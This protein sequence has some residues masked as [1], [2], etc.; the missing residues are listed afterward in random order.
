MKRIK[1]AAFLMA[2][3]IF[4][5]IIPL[6]AVASSS[7]DDEAFA[8]DFCDTSMTLADEPF[9]TEANGAADISE[10]ELYRAYE[11]FMQFTYDNELP[12]FFD[13]VSF[14]EQYIVLGYDGVEDYLDAL[15][16]MFILPPEGNDT[17]SDNKSP[18]H[19]WAD[20]QK[21]DDY[22][23][24]LPYGAEIL[25]AYEHFVLYFE[26]HDRIVELCLEDFASQCENLDVYEIDEL[27]NE[28][29]SQYTQAPI[30]PFATE[31]P[32]S[33]SGSSGSSGDS[34]YYYDIG[35]SLNVAP[36]YKKYNILQLAQ[37]GDIVLDKKGSGGVFG[38]AAIVE[39]KFYSTQYG[40]YIRV[41]ESIENG[42]RRGLWDAV[43]TDDRDSY[44]YKVYTA[45]PG[46]K[47]AAVEFC[48]T[49]LGKDWF[50]NLTHEYGSDTKKW[51]CSQLIW[52]AYKNQGLDIEV[53]GG[54]G[55]EP[56][57]TPHDITIN[58][59]KVTHV[60]FRQALDTVP[61]GTY[62]LTNYNS[63]RRLD[64]RGGQLANSTSIQQY[65]AGVQRRAYSF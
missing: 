7:S 47:T 5:Q 51:L 57:V 42:V 31:Q 33:R 37:K 36:N 21:P 3:V 6:T 26:E 56:G 54:D 46:Q 44:L 32:V 18:I 43:R 14:K 19:E 10:A 65:S 15:Y 17:V 60:D 2:I 16:G 27:C 22:R 49:Q 52:A 40:Y 23:E 64:V 45:T 24:G 1:M 11:T 35:S 48:I 4:C 9:E 59:S 25:D 61:N 20:T 53:N 30:S 12:V 39:G 13:F 34:E 62:Y 58:S 29:K 55:G 28:L 63:G 8:T 38:H 50:F 41:I